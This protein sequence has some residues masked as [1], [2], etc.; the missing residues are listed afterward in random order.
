MFET[1]LAQPTTSGRAD[2]LAFFLCS[3]QL[4]VCAGLAFA[5]EPFFTQWRV[6]ELWLLCV[7]AGREGQQPANGAAETETGMATATT[8]WTI[9]ITT[10]G[11]EVETD[12]AG[13]PNQSTVRGR[14][15]RA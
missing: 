1:I 15:S 7:M 11:T 6:N 10:V 5:R 4:G 13:V 14:G 2:T 12:S 9:N 8:E 3:K